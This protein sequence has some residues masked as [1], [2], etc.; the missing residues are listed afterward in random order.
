MR[1]RRK[2]RSDRDS[3]KWDLPGRTSE[4][5][6][7]GSK[8]W[9]TCPSVC[10]GDRNSPAG[11]RRWPVSSSYLC[12]FG[13]DPT[14]SESLTSRCPLSKP[15]AEFLSPNFQIRSPFQIT[16]ILCTYL[17]HA[18]FRVCVSRFQLL[19]RLWP[20][21]CRSSLPTLRDLD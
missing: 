2:A 1:A 12:I 10:P 7:T 4:A 17:D 14:P 8:P 15:T 16:L 18:F 13:R 19:R 11:S 5:F 9:E 21:P 3:S 20:A 6:A